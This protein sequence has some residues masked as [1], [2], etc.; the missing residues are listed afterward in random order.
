MFATVARGVEEVISGKPR[1]NAAQSERG[2]GRSQPAG[3]S[4][5]IVLCDSDT[6]V[7]NW[8]NRRS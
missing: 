4:G 1:G 2:L 5:M 8:A 6:T 3:S 7:T